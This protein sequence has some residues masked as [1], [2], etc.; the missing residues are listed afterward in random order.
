MIRP[1]PALTEHAGFLLAR[2]GRSSMLAYAARLAPLGLHP[3]HFGLLRV[4]E[5][6]GPVTQGELGR[7]AGIDPSTMVGALDELEAKG[8]L[9]RRPHPGDRRA[10]ELHLTPAARDAMAAATAAAREH[11]E[12]F[13]APLTRDERAELLRLLQKLAA[14]E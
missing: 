3:K 8:L 6:E 10:H 11:A 12:Q 4:L 1:H 7:L 13:F 2:L 14:A 9:E 5:A